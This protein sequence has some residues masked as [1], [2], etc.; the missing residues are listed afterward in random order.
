MVKR[1]LIRRMINTKRKIGDPLPK[2]DSVIRR[3]L[4][5]IEHILLEKR[6]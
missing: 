3:N 4:E 6:V 5:R 2:S 1:S